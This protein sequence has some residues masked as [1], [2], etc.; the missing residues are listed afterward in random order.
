LEPAIPVSD[1]IK[2]ISILKRLPYILSFDA[3]AAAA[4]D[5]RVELSQTLPPYALYSHTL[6]L[7]PFYYK[8]NFTYKFTMSDHPMPMQDYL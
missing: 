8:T 1:L 4:R 6:A 2:P 7:P 3:Y 5:I